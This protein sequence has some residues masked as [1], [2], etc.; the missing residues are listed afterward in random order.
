MHWHRDRGMRVEG[1]EAA[2][3]L[4][5]ILEAIVWHPLN[6]AK[7]RAIPAGYGPWQA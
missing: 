7:W 4:R 2:A 1:H 5:R 6:G 3:G